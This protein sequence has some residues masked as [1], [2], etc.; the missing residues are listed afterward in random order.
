M[1]KKI[2]EI[3]VILVAIILLGNIAV[4][5]F[6]IET[7]ETLKFEIK[8]SKPIEK[9]LSIGDMKFSKIEFEGNN[10]LLSDENKP[11]L[12]M[13]RKIITLPF[14]SKINN[15]ECK[16]SEINSIILLNKV[17]PASKS[18]ILSELNNDFNLDFD[19]N[20]Y[21]SNKLY[22]ENWITYYINGGLDENNVHKTILTIFVNPTRYNPVEDKI[23]YVENIKIIID[24][25]K[26]S[27]PL[28]NGNDEY[29]MVII[30]PSLFQQ[31]IE[32][33]I[34]H[35]YNIGIR[36]FLKTTEEIF[37]EYSGFDKP[38]KIKYFIKDSIENLGIRYVLIIG[39]LNSLIYA[40]RKDDCNQGS[41]DWYVP[42]RYTNVK[43]QGSVNDPGYISDLYY[44]DIYDS[45]GNFSSWDSN[46]DEIYASWKFGSYRDDIDLLP[47][48][49]VGRLPCRNAR[50]VNTMIDKIINYE[51]TSP[52]EKPW[53]NKIIAIGGDTFGDGTD[54]YEGE[55]ETQKAI[56]YMD[57]FEPVILWTSN[58]DT[59]G[60]TP[61]PENI[62]DTI[63]EG[64]GFL[65]FAGHG[66][67]ELWYTYYPDPNHEETVDN[68]MWYLTPKCS[69]ED[70]L[71]VCVVGSCHGS[72][73]N[74][75]ALSFLSLWLSRLGDLLDIEALKI[76]PG[77]CGFPT[78]ECFC[79]SLTKVLNGGTISTIGNTGIGYGRTGNSG[80][81]D[82]DGIDDPDCIETNGGYLE[83]LF[84]K[85][86]GID[87]IDIL[88]ETWGEAIRD[89]LYVFPGMSSQVHLKTI[90]QWIL[91]G[92]P[93]LK[94][95][96][97]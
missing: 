72:Q 3:F 67:P 21:S 84:F 93:S 17:I 45:D 30:S 82:G 16:T 38:E 59:G 29:D 46:N 5:G 26:P 96:G 23:I 22:P 10:A 81:L 53:F 62:I 32:P 2:F 65:H 13:Y 88:G 87:N 89:Y 11:V 6:N 27:K 28:L 25:N 42:V 91:F 50:E 44:A 4:S 48:I 79:W 74:V 63:S 14:G 76:W 77:N 35:K 19:E 66:S 71:P 57:G 64:S 24:Y 69:N 34:E 75:T 85:A 15:I 20:I 61:E 7:S 18:V 78:P 43:E 33:L 36:T 47:D 95:G 56:D 90:Q 94:I 68:F 9:E 54:I 52:E 39:G 60:L 92:D 12:P 70:K 8:I 97:Y 49:Y 55:V 83:T 51:S 80:D 58:R 1:N 37:N 86:Y 31:N 73:F 40:Q 41:N